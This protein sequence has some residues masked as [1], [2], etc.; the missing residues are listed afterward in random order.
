MYM[1]IFAFFG[2]LTYATSLLL[3]SVDYEYLINALPFLIG[4]GGVLLFD[5]IAFVQYK[6][7]KENGNYE[8]LLERM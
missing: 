4:S 5:L 2:N 6:M 1:F 7:Y 3:K 8:Q